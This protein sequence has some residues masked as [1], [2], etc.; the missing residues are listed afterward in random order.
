MSPL[1]RSLAGGKLV[2]AGAV[3]AASRR[4]RAAR[5]CMP[6]TAVSAGALGQADG[7]AERLGARTR[8]P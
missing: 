5:A 4:A 1:V 7:Q 3:P 8:G 2:V 6:L